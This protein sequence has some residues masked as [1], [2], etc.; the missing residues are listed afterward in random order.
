MRAS[1]PGDANAGTQNMIFHNR[2]TPKE[3]TFVARPNDKEGYS[4]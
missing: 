1:G 2:T 4:D 3:P